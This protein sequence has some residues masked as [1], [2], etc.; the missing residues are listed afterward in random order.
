MSALTLA[1]VVV[2][3][4]LA[5]FAYLCW[6]LRNDLRGVWAVLRNIGYGL[7]QLWCW[8]YCIRWRVRHGLQGFW[9]QTA[10]GVLLSGSFYIFVELAGA[11]AREVFH[12]SGGS[13]GPEA[14]EGL[15][16]MLVFL[17]ALKAPPLWAE[18]LLVALAAAVLRHHFHEWKLRKRE[19]V[20]PGELTELI[21]ICRPFLVAGSALSE[22]KRGEFFAKAMEGMV[23]ILKN[24]RKKHVISVSLT[25]FSEDRGTLVV[26]YVF[27]DKSPAV[28]ADTVLAPNEGAAGKVFE[29]KEAIY[30]PSTRH[31]AGINMKTYQTAGLLFA[32]REGIDPGPSLICVPIK[33]DSTVSAVINVSSNKRNAFGP[34][35]VAVVRLVAVLLADADWRKPN[36]A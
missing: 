7:W 17:P 16:R 3:L 22:E 2:A 18:I 26:A 1:V 35:D 14:S 36:A 27:P 9:G 24:G 32:K 4:V 28:D 33:R 19:A 30:V 13:E 25:T 34:L 8:F 6:Y 15:G 21:P 29:I 11:L 10:A 12:Q 20:V 31:L 5:G 23:R